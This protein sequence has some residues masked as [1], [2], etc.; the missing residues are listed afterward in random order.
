[1][2]NTDVH[3]PEIRSYNMSRIHGKNTKKEN[4]VQLVKEDI[5]L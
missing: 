1:M 4:D 3:S 2:T 5:N